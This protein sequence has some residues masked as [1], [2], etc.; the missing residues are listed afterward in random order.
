MASLYEL[1]VK[2]TPH[3]YND[4]FNSFEDQMEAVK[5]AS[6]VYVGN[7]SFKTKEQ[8]IFFYFSTVGSIKKIIMGLDRLQKTPCGFCFVVYNSSDEAQKAADYLDNTL[9]D[10]RTIKVERDWGFSEGRQYG[11]SK[12]GMQKR[13]YYRTYE[14][15]DR[16]S[17]NT[18]PNEERRNP[19]NN[20]NRNNNRN[21]NRNNRYPRYDN[22]GDR[23]FNNNKRRYEDNYD[24]QRRS[25][26]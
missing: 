5:K 20:Y 11:R 16:G 25:R 14:D 8:Q 17:M 2:K 15:P 24:N 18:L 1:P 22:Y 10:N 7:L 12:S 21:Y 26:Y 19:F 4:F 13:D 3:F 6:T 9:L 23:N